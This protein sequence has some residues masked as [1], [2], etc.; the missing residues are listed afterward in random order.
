MKKSIIYGILCVGVLFTITSCNK[1]L[2]TKSYE[3]VDA[4][5][6][7]S[8]Y[9]TANAALNGVYNRMMV[10]GAYGRYITGFPECLTNNLRL[11]A[12][13]TN[14]GVGHFQWNIPVSSA[15]LGDGWAYMYQAINRANMVIR[16]VNDISASESQIAEIKGQAL[17]LRA[18][19]HFDLLRIHAQR[20]TGNTDGLGIPYMREPIAPS[21]QPARNTIGQC[22]TWIIQDLKDAIELLKVKEPTTAVYKMTLIGAKSLLA[23]V[24]MSQLDYTN[25]KPLL[26]DVV[27]TSGWTILGNSEYKAAWSD[28]YSLNKKEFIFA[29]SYT[30]ATTIATNSLGYMY[31]QGG[32]GDWV[33]DK[34]G[35]PN[36]L[37]DS[38]SANDVRKSSFYIAGTGTKSAYQMINKYPSR[39]NDGGTG[40]S[41][42]PIL[43]MSDMYLLYAEACAY[44]SDEATA[45][46]YLDKIRQ[47]AEPTATATTA[48]GEALKDLIFTERRKEMAFEGV[49]YYDLKRYGM[50]IPTG[51]A[52]DGKPYVEAGIPGNSVKLAHQI[53]QSEMDANPNMVQNPVQ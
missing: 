38:Y 7:I 15:D 19:F 5:G 52:D 2:D 37:Y 46:E 45:I 22:Y 30:A 31:I 47:R 23:R 41:D 49:Y 35:Q 3:Q 42:V 14:R 18:M 50:T 10:S 44:T 13:N 12:V 24:Y 39:A 48:S 11:C 25:A 40:L 20:Y 28:K 26:K 21:V 36:S 29:L 1:F 51:Q 6:I 32:Y 53:P 16:D 34:P 17:A 8:D 9:T 27:E 43:R 4:D 33:G